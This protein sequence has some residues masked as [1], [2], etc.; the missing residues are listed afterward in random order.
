MNIKMLLNFHGNYSKKIFREIDLLD[1]T[2][3][4]V[5][6]FFNFLAHCGREMK[7]RA[8]ENYHNDILGRDC[9]YS[10]CELG[11]KIGS[12]ELAYGIATSVG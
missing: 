3:F 1:F 9:I 11:P 8:A 12:E 4:L 7:M 6:T 5:W 2:S 10:V